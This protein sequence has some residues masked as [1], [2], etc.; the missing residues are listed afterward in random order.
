MFGCF[1]AAPQRTSMVRL[2]LFSPGSR[3]NNIFHLSYSQGAIKS[4]GKFL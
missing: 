4:L 1:L 3:K 2:G